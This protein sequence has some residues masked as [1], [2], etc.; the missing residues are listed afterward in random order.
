MPEIPQLGDPITAHGWI[1][2]AIQESEAFLKAQQGYGKIAESMNMVFGDEDRIRSI[3]LS[4][5]EANHIGKIASDLGALLTD[6]KP[7]WEYQTHNKQFERQ[8]SILGKLSTHW[9]Q[10][11]MIDL[12][13]NQVVKYYTVGGTGFPHIMWDPDIQDFTIH[14]ED[15][16]DV[17]PIRPPTGYISIQD[18]IGVIIRREHTVNHLRS[19]YPESKWHLIKP[20]RDGSL[21]G[22][23]VSSTRF[24]R[25]LQRLGV[26]P[27]SPFQRSL[28]GGP[29]RQTPKV[30]MADLY[31]VYLKDESTNKSDHPRFV[32]DFDKQGRALNNWSYIVA[33]GQRLYP[34]GRRIVA[35]TKGILKDGPNPYWHGLFP[36]PKMTLDPWPWSWF[37][38]APLWDLLKLQGS[39]NR[40]LRI[41]DDTM[42]QIARPGLIADKNSVSKAVLEKYDTRRAGWKFQHNPIAGKGLQVVNPPPLPGEVQWYVEFIIDQMAT[43]SGVRDLG[44]LMQLNQLPGADTIEKITSSMTATVRG[45]SRAM[46]AFFREFG[47]IMSYNFAQFYTLPMRMTILGPD[48]VTKEDFDFEPGTFIPAYAHRED[49]DHQ[50]I[51][52]KEAITRGPYPAYDRAREFLRQFS[53][54]VAPGSLLAAS[55]IE[56]KL[57]YLQLARGG[58][59]DRWTLYEVLGIP[60]A[61]LPPNNANTITERLVAE[62]EMGLGMQVSPVGRK[63]TAQTMP[64]MSGGKVV[65]S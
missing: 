34:R 48:G 24:G 11:R 38:K 6:I 33:P 50:G 25:M 64:R 13:M 65:E 45:R 49:F 15:P 60:N 31:T 63:A 2:E 44:Q 4:S 32:G 19:L 17:L 54:H 39:L 1:N 28:W 53:F 51:P 3:H 62:Q 8:Q 7:F 26:P 12:R 36:L 10:Q 46:E 27:D 56:R 57:L 9:Y 35:T 43:L 5:T 18:S 47:T 29:A 22:Q 55:E 61:G 40:L 14:A 21:R 30:P 16:R 58:L 41:I 20:D 59:I 42:E 23:D 37:G 52:T